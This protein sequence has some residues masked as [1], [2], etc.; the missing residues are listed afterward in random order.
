MIVK[1]YAV[2]TTNKAAYFVSLKPT[3][4]NSCKRGLI[5]LIKLYLTILLFI[6]NLILNF[7]LT[8]LCLRQRLQ[9]TCSLQ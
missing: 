7:T 8:V 2:V 6:L 4:K 9:L 5:L 3:K 1:E